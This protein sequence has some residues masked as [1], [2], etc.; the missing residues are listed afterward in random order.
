V[1][2]RRSMNFRRLRIIY[3]VTLVIRL[4]TVAVLAIAGWGAYA[5]IIG[6]NVAAS[7]PFGVDLLLIQRWRPD[8]GWNRWPHWQAYRPALKFGLQQAGSGL[9]QGLRG[10]IESMVLPATLGFGLIGLWNRAQGLYSMSVG[11]TVTVIEETA[12]PLLPRLAGSAPERYPTQAALYLQVVMWLAV[13]G[14]AFVGLCGP[15][16]SRLLYGARWIQADPFLWPGSLAGLSTVAITGGHSILLA[17]NRLRTCF[18]LNVIS[19]VLS[20]LAI[21]VA[22][23]GQAP[24]VYVWA[25]TVAQ[26]AAAVIVL[27][28]ASA[29]LSAAWWRHVLFPSALATGLATAGLISLRH[30]LPDSPLAW[31]ISIEFATFCAAQVLVLRVAFRA[32]L[33]NVVQRLPAA[34]FCRT[35]LRLGTQL[36]AAPDPPC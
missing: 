21:S 11:R 9:L 35:C 4:G 28:K 20:V 24:L 3:G 6:S 33:D 15:E 29:L 23:T 18:T 10:G 2:L 7:V 5:I 34:A 31:R 26:V 19:T 14:V 25:V 36:E 27:F 8:P 32:S 22:L 30:F 16:L 17:A 1:M 12:Y 13:P